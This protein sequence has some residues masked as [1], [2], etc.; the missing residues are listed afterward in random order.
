MRLSIALELSEEM[1][2]HLSGFQ[3]KFR[4]EH[5]DFSW[6]ERSGFFVTLKFLGNPRRTKPYQLRGALKKAASQIPPFEFTLDRAGCFPADG[7]PRVIWVGI[8]ES[9]GM[10]ERFQADCESLFAALGVSP[11]E[12][13]FMPHIVI[14]R[15]ETN[16][17]KQLRKDVESSRIE[18]LL[19]RAES[20][21]L[22]Q[23]KLS[24][25]GP[26]YGV[27]FRAPFTATVVS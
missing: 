2:E 11:D 23:S 4:E 16:T 3:E 17:S 22:V 21:C 12:K 9:T 7:T 15:A 8:N 25:S 20:V 6:I 13:R 27:L 5:P 14:G 26:E 24:R 1:L 10:L 18:P 19:H